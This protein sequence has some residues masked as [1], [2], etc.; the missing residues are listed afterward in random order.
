MKHVLPLVFL[1][2]LGCGGGDQAGGTTHDAGPEPSE[3]CDIIGE[4]GVRLCA[5]PIDD[6]GFAGFVSDEERDAYCEENPDFTGCGELGQ[7]A[8]PLT[9]YQYHGQGSEGV[10]CYSMRSIGVV[11]TCTWPATKF[12][13]FK[14]GN[15]N[16]VTADYTFEQRAYVTGSEEAW[17]RQSISDA[18]YSFQ[19]TSGMVLSDSQGTQAVHVIA[20]N[21]EINEFGSAGLFTGYQTRSSNGPVAPNGE[22]E[23]VLRTST[24]AVLAINWRNIVEY[25]EDNCIGG[26]SEQ[27]IRRKAYNVAIH[28]FL[29]TMGFAHFRTGVMTATS[30]CDAN[31][32]VPAQGFLNAITVYNAP[33]PGITILPDNGLAGQLP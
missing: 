4:N 2:V 23:G 12:I 10:P 14:P 26:R 21:P 13:W 30:G 7:T 27:N 24:T 17:I 29:H 16:A 33:S 1:C 6:P 28:E 22:D 31:Y 3:M 25:V 19:N 18:L 5:D 11:G 15:T 32:N 20:S 9:S 8:Q